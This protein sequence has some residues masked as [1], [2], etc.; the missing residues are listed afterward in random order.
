MARKIFFFVKSHF[1]ER[2]WDTVRNVPE[3]FEALYSLQEKPYGSVYTA[4][5]GMNL[6]AKLKVKLL[7]T[8]P[9]LNIK[10]VPSI[11]NQVDFIYTWGYLPLGAK[12]PF[13]IE[14][15]NPYCFTYYNP[16]AFYKYKKLIKK[17]LNKAYKLT[18]M[19]EASMYHFLHEFGV[20]FK[21]KSVVFYPYAKRRY[22]FNHNKDHKQ[23]NFLFV[24]LDYKIKGLIELLEAFSHVNSQNINLYVVSFISENIKRRFEKDKRIIFLE[25]MSR[26]KLLT[27][28]YPKMD[29]F[30][31][32]SFYESFGVVL[33]EALSFGLGL[34]A[35]NV[36]AVPELLYNEENGILLHHPF[37]KPENFCGKLII[38]PVKYHLKEF[39]D[40]Y[41][42]E[43][44]F[45]Y[46]LYEELK[47]AIKRA[48][49]EC[50][51]WKKSSIEIFEERFS[52]DIWKRRFREIFTP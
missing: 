9:L 32:P 39:K 31:M 41:L 10:K 26:E 38:N 2:Q 50:H 7:L 23:I 37:L 19:S 47:E 22:K 48:I 12:K 8:I 14:I 51:L 28:V 20:K 17:F 25:P 49:D 52:E 4:K 34:I 6:F 1:R 13:V 3:G 21:E 11:A 33:L 30:I 27:E 15:D 5:R 40:L 29:V 43:D 45:Y 16:N 44:F 18:F 35:T 36:Y 42:K 46:S 24:G